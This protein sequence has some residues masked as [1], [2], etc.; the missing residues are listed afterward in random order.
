MKIF[1]AD[2]YAYLFKIGL[3]DIIPLVE[4][5]KIMSDEALITNKKKKKL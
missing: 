4:K 2:L 3:G 1:V 5:L